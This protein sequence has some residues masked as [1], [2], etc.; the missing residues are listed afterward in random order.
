MGFRSDSILDQ[1]DI[2]RSSDVFVA[3]TGIT[4]GSLLRGVHFGRQG[5]ETASLVIHERT[6]SVR[7]VRGVLQRKHLSRST[8][9]YDG[10]GG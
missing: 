8:V 9:Q 7:Y 10:E 3:A 6:G 1:N 2:I 4:E 5:V